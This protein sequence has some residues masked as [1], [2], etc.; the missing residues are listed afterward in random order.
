MIEVIDIEFSILKITLMEK[1][2]HVVDTW[3]IIFRTL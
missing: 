3:F 2:K 1:I